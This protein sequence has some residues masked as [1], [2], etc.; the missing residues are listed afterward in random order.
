M[1]TAFQIAYYPVGH[2]HRGSNAQEWNGSIG[3]VHEIDVAGQNQLGCHCVVSRGIIFYRATTTAGGTA[4]PGL[5]SFAIASRRQWPRRA[6][7]LPAG[8]V[9]IQRC[10]EAS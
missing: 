7:R 6:A 2:V 1:Q 5:L 9:T 10:E 8:Y 4:S 3:D